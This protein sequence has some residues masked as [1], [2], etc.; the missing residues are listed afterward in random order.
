M[1]R[2]AGDDIT[3]TNY[4]NGTGCRRQTQGTATVILKY[5]V[6]QFNGVYTI[7][8]EPVTVTVGKTTATPPIRLPRKHHRVATTTPNIPGGSPRHA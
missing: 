2:I 4:E 7:Y 1:M 8:S 3:F 5:E 6:E